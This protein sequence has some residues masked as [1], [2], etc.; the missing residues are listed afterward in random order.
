MVHL[1][2][3]GF[4]VRGALTVG[5]L[6]HSDR[7]VVGPAMVEAYRLESK[8]AKVPRIIIDEKVLAVARRSRGPDHSAK[9]AEGYVRAFMTKDADGHHYLDYVSWKAV[10][11]ITGGDNDG[12]GEYLSRIGKLVK[13][14]LSHE[15]AR[16]QEKYLW[17][18]EQ[19]VA[20]I[21]LV[22]SLPPDNAYRLEN[23]EL[24]AGVEALSK[25]EALAR[26]AQ[27]AVAT[28]S[29]PVQ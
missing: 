6:Y 12:Y 24:C 27:D 4:L 3:I 19:Y 15:H 13:A 22:A 11:E 20:A 14:G 23:P 5:D 21:E 10:V 29:R 18:H 9:E 8:V 2:E 17:L 7:H 25:Y 16:V 28:P 26:A 1:A